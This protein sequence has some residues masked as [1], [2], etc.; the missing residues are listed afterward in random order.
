MHWKGLWSN[1]VRLC[2]PGRS[3]SVMQIKESQAK[4][5]KENTEGVV[6][7]KRMLSFQWTEVTN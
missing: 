1:V 4:L 3:K 2:R 5:S 6:L 7:D